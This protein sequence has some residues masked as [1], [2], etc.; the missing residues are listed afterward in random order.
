M[1]VKK[2]VL[3]MLRTT[4]LTSVACLYRVAVAICLNNSRRCMSYCAILRLIR[5]NAPCSSDSYHQDKM[6]Y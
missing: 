1:L 5:Q 3:V 6:L 2:V 4:F